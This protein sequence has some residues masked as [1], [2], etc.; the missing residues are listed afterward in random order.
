[1]AMRPSGSLPI[2]SLSLF[3][4]F[5]ITS[6]SGWAQAKL[7]KSLIAGP[8]DESRLTILKGNTHPLARPEFDSGAAPPSL[9]M[10][11]M[12]LVLKRNPEQEAA[13]EQFLDQQ[14]D[15]S[16]PNFHKWLTP[17]QFGAEY[18]PGTEDIQQITSWLE[19]HG[20][21][22]ARVSNGRSVIEF[23][24]TAGQVSETFHTAIHKYN[25]DGEESWAN[26]NDPAIPSAL[27]S[28][29][30]G[31]ASLNSFPK[32]SALLVRHEYW[33]P[34][35]NSGAQR[36]TP[37]FTFGS[38][39]CGRQS[40]VCHALGPTDL[41]TIYNV[42]PLWNSGIDGTGQAVAI[43]AASNM[44]VQ[45]VRDFRSL[46]G[47]PAKDPVIILNGPDPGLVQSA[48]QQV[49]SEA[50]AD[51][52]WTGAVAKNATLYLVVSKTTNSTAGQDLSS[53][54]IVDHNLAPVL[55]ASYGA[56]ELP[57]GTAGNQFYRQLWQ[58]GAAQG[59]SV[60][61]SAAD[62][63]SANC[64]NFG[65]PPPAPAKSGLKVSGVASTP[66]NVAVGGTDF[67][68]VGNQASF[69]NPTNDP[70]T[71]ASAKGYIPEMA[72]NDSCTNAAFGSSSDPETNCSD[73]TLS[74]FVRTSGGGGGK[75]NCTTS[76]GKNPS[77]CS[78]GYPKPS[79]QAGPGVPNDGAR[80]IPDVSLFAAGG[81]AS[82]SFYV[83]CEADRIQDN[84]GARCDLNSPF[85]H[86]VAGEGTSLSVQ[87]F[88]GIMALVNQ[89]T[90]S[91]QGNANSV[92]YA[93][94]AQQS[95]GN[96]NS[97]SP[98]TTCIFNDTT[99]G[100][101]SMPCTK[102]SPDCSTTNPAHPYGVLSG[103]NA[104]SGY[105]LA[106][107]LGSVNAF[108][109]INASGWSNN[110]AAPDFIL[111]AANP[112]VAVSAPG[113]S[114]TMTLTFT[115]L[116]GFSGTFAL[117]AAACTAMPAGSSCSFSPGSVTISQANPTATVTLTVATTK[118]SMLIPVS[119]HSKPSHWTSEKLV[120]LM[121]VF[122]IVLLLL[123]IRQ[124]Q[125]R[126]ITACAL[127]IF[128]LIVAAGGC[129]SGSGNN[130][131]GGGSGGTPAG[132]TNGVITL[133]SGNTTHSFVFTLRIQ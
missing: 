68:D 78:G 96:C 49:E 18:G 129:S 124:S 91:R 118:P 70:A 127:L 13:L 54:Y 21:Q 79:W 32:R 69:W 47:L 113:N 36:V 93:L 62:S 14:L 59:I 40:N 42:L 31:I 128:G 6:T 9:P 28:I 108:N 130:G 81:L 46:F 67:N 89:K 121:W 100:T 111:S 5:I 39:L 88:G 92:L 71:Q 102:G 20:F 122:C 35:G 45:D 133:T 99:V 94:A 8:V 19:A 73:P 86:F 109:L 132:T 3:A 25:V 1:M 52:E 44:N 116:N 30:V 7:T 27:A 4:V 15:K 105:D 66:Y 77:S 22:A 37:Q 131:G 107:G 84:S 55:S 83:V 26:S 125:R 17:E 95:A 112:V 34:M 87:V 85:M 114:G 74:S 63:G 119:L 61:V 38:S 29:V 103:Y 76:D 56:C 53:E 80:D 104:G 11:R 82:G 24:G 60:L 120:A 72:W 65:T 58:Q 90:N 2:R 23:S 123:G 110:T 57:L 50:V 16:S 48:A 12:L 97:S 126:R 106:T 115:S 98:A 64:D 43:V 117:N 51:L 41:A 101:I 33:N 75:S 10:E